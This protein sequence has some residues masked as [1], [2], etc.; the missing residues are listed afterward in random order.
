MNWLSTNLHERNINNLCDFKLKVTPYKF[1]KSSFVDSCNDLANNIYDYNNNLYIGL[2]GGLDSEYVLKVFIELDIPITPL[3]VSTSFNKN[4]LEYAFDFC[5]QNKIIPKVFN[6]ED[7]EF[8][9]KLHDKTH[10]RG[11]FALLGGLPLLLADYVNDEKGI[12]INGYGD[13]FF[14]EGKTVPEKLEI[15]EWDYYLDCYDQRHISAFYS[16]NIEVFYS[17]AS[18]IDYGLDLQNA[19]SKLY[20]L[21]HR[22]KCYFDARFQHISGILNDKFKPKHYRLY[23]DKDYLLSSLDAYTV[24]DT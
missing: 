10:K 6:Y 8:I 21:K 16:H 19:K 24:L 12:L 22:E 11:M 7:D 14:V 23:L 2:S 15:S 20:G 5:N 18:E 1:V 9:Y 4:E 17:M 13:P 3:I